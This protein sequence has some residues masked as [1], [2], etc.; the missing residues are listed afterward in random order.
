M[1]LLLRWP[2]GARL[3]GILF[4]LVGQTNPY[5]SGAISCWN[6][7]LPIVAGTLD[8]ELGLQPTFPSIHDGIPAVFDDANSFY[9]LPSN[10]NRLIG[11]DRRFWRLTQ[12]G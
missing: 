6:L 2:K 4:P 10:L 8:H 5:A 12:Y 11:L 3:L 7:A 9:W 1:H